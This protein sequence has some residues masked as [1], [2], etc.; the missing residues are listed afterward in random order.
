MPSTLLSA[1]FAALLALLPAA[2]AGFDP[3]SAKNL[4]VYW[5]QNSYGQV[6][7]QQRLSYYC[8]NGAGIN[9]IPISFLESIRNPLINL[10]N[11]GD[12]CTTFPGTQLLNCPQVEEDI[13][14]CQ[15]TYGKTIM[16]SIGGAT[17]TEGG[18]S[19]ASVAV[20]A[21]QN[22]W[23]MFGPVQSG[24]SAMRPFGSAVV[25]GFDFD[26]ES[27]VQNMEPFVEE[28]RTLID[29]ASGKH[30]LSA[31]PQCPYPDLADESFI[32]GQV[33]IDWVQ[34]QFYNN[35]CG[36]GQYPTNWNFDTWDNWAK[37]VSA[38]KNAKVLIGIPAN[39]GGAG[40]GS[41]AHGAQLAGAINNG[42]T[43]SS[44]GGVMA[45]DMSQLFNNQGFLAEILGD[46]GSSP[47]PPP[48]PTTTTTSTTTTM[49]STTMT[50]ITTKPA[51]PTNPP[52]AFPNGVNAVVMGT[53]AQPSAWLHT[54]ASRSVS[55][56]PSASKQATRY[57]PA[58]QLARLLS[59]IPFIVYNSNTQG[60]HEMVGRNMGASAGTAFVTWSTRGHCLYIVS[61]LALNIFWI[62]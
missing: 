46:L 41:Y 55:G 24:N 38:N 28:L 56:G 47:P 62:L 17:Y 40:G 32:N 31:A 19:S 43:Y 6:G 50:T 18:F 14:E 23:A 58:P 27:T 3:N 37:N 5:G 7:S 16:L 44:F 12:N 35:F 25:D 26:F 39:V 2:Q 10:A 22:I 29:Q 57:R 59:S 33:D 60:E 42:K 45:W 9:I 34:V 1:S 30:Y 48:P 54:P 49:T 51:G 11:A 4:A 13:K 8:Q 36:V 52:A 53:P 20:A 21:A 15:S 61:T